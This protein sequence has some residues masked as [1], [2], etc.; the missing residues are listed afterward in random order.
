MTTS[1]NTYIRQNSAG[2]LTGPAI[3]TVTHNETCVRIR[4]AW[5]IFP[6]ALTV[7]MFVFFAAMVHH[8]SRTATK[9]RSHN[10]KNNALPLVYHGLDASEPNDLSDRG[11][12]TM[13]EI[14]GD[15][16]DKYVTL[17]STEKGWRLV[18]MYRGKKGG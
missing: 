1:L 8:T 16:K 5:L 4:W 12:M 10:F 13:S 15:A 7:L 11:W 17:S 9:V 6:A 14:D 18:E 3:G 2:V